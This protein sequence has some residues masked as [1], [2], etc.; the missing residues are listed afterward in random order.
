MKLSKIK[1]YIYDYLEFNFDEDLNS[2][3]IIRE[4]PMKELSEMDY[5]EGNSD[6]KPKN[7]K[8]LEDKYN[9]GIFYNH[10]DVF[11]AKCPSYEVQGK[12]GT[13]CLS[14]RIAI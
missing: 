13:Y 12:Y 5:F 2:L 6:K 11:I 3:T 1:E 9:S 7:F 14:K 10:C 8:E 4:I